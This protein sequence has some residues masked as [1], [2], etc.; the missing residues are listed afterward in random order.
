MTL[1]QQAEAARILFAASTAL[2]GTELKALALLLSHG[3]PGARLRISNAEI[4]RGLGFHVGSLRRVLHSLR[5]AINPATGRPWIEAGGGTRGRTIVVGR[6]PEPDRA[7]DP[8]PRA[9]PPHD[10]EAIGIG[11][12]AAPLPGQLPLPFAPRGGEP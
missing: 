12:R 11:P 8:G 7:R 1:R 2:G 5:T 9:A 10:D 4:A 3:P 6:Q